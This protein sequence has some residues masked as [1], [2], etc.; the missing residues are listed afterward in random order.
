KQRF[1]G[2]RCRVASR[3]R[4]GGLQDVCGGTKHSR[5]TRQR[6]ESEGFRASRQA[7]FIAPDIM[8]VHAPAPRSRHG[9]ESTPTTLYDPALPF[10]GFKESG[11]GRDQGKDALEKYTQTKSV[12]VNL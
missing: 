7:G 1:C 9:L 8:V 12:W 5:A 4:G 10:G 2:T 6:S 11:F 3:D